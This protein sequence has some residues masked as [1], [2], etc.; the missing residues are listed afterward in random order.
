VKEKQIYILGGESGGHNNDLLSVEILD[1]E[2]EQVVP[3][4]NLPPGY[5]HKGVTVDGNDLLVFSYRIRHH[6]ETG[7][8]HSLKHGE[9]NAAWATRPTAFPSNL[10]F[11][12][13]NAPAIGHC[14]LA[15]KGKSVY[16]TKRECWWDL[17]ETPFEMFSLV[18]PRAVLGGKEIVPFTSTG[19]F[20]LKLKLLVNPPTTTIL[21]YTSKLYES[22]LFSPDFSDVTFVCPEGIEISAHRCVLAANNAYFKAYFQSPWL[23]LHP[24]GRWETEKSADVLKALLSLIYTGKLS[25]DVTDSKLVQIL[26][27]SYEFQLGKDLLR[28]VQAKCIESISVANV[29]ELLLFAKLHDASFL[30]DAC[31]N[32]VCDNF[33]NVASDLEFA[34]DIIKVDGQLWQD[35]LHSARK[36]SRKRQRSD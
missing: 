5:E 1:T 21:Q 19:V 9:P 20:S 6:P 4:Q 29:K 14:V 36:S 7:E 22:L 30:F 2:T 17:P 25:P 23:E 34:G 31:F 10:V 3:G 18:R 16:D 28:V 13:N 33:F 27:T 35:I 24:D 32:F 12:D 8:I 11:A 15:T 26:E